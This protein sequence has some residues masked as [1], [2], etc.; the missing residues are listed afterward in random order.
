IGD[1]QRV[2]WTSQV[3]RRV[4]AGD[5]RLIEGVEHISAQFDDASLTELD[6]TR[7]GQIRRTDEAALQVPVA[8]L[9]TNAAHS[10]SGEGIRVELMER[11][12]AATA[13]QIDVG[14]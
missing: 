3:H 2:C 10:R 13:T 9:K 12:A 5:A 14:P 1:G 7:D 11:I 4:T 8:G 6:G